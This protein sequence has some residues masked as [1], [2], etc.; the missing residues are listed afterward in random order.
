[1]SILPFFCLFF[2]FFAKILLG[3]SGAVFRAFQGLAPKDLLAG[4]GVL[5]VA[6]LIGRGGSVVRVLAQYPGGRGFVIRASYTVQ[7]RLGGAESAGAGFVCFAIGKR[8][9]VCPCQSVSRFGRVWA[10]LR[11]QPRPSNK[12]SKQVFE[13]KSGCFFVYFSESV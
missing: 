10:W 1:M 5:R 6:S 3:V 11:L 7:K 4:L 9:F 2:K 12:C 8:P 13:K